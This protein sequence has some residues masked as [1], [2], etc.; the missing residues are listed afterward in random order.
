MN[1]ERNTKGA[2]RK[3]L[4]DYLKKTTLHNFRLPQWLADW[5]LSHKGEGSKLLEEALVQHFHLKPQEIFIM[6]NT[7]RQILDAIPS[8]YVF[9]SHFVIQ[10]LLKNHSDE[11]L[12]FAAQY[13]DNTRPTFVTHGQIG[14]LIN[15]FVGERI[16]QIELPGWSENIH[17]NA[18]KC[19]CWRKL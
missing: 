12:Q 13:A 10:Q 2:G 8:N 18:S 16:D 7:I 9:D 5:L 3:S 19:T 17:G 6:Q 14:Q 4:P 1:T 11:Y 15:G